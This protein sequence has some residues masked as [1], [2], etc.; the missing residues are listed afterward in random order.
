MSAKQ[1]N[2]ES[3]LQ[4]SKLR[5]TKTKSGCSKIGG[6]ITVFDK[7][8]AKDLNYPE[9]REIILVHEVRCEFLLTKIESHLLC[10][11][12]SDSTV[13]DSPSISLAN[14]SI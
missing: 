2:P 3:G 14:D 13:L 1:K 7:G 6:K 5:K 8:K 10:S 12:I 11:W 4:T 9:V